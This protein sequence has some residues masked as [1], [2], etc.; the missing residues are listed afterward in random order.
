MLYAPIDADLIYPHQN[1]WKEETNQVSYQ[2]ET[3]YEYTEVKREYVTPGVIIDDSNYSE[4]SNGITIIEPPTTEETTTEST[5]DMVIINFQNT[6]TYYGEFTLTA[7]TWTGNTCADGCY[8][9]A[10]Y[11]AACNDPNLWHKWV[12]IDG[13]GDRYIQDTGGM[14]SG[15]IDIYYDTYNECVSFGSCNAS[16][17]VYE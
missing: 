14:G 3:D 1:E 2:E 8:P 13:V 7:Y 10:G 17:Y 15:T 6:S 11:T 5:D 4:E 16:V 9:T 12:Y